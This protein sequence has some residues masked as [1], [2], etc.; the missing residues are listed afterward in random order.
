MNKKEEIFLKKLYKFAKPCIFLPLDY[1]WDCKI[2]LNEQNRNQNFILFRL[3]FGKTPYMVRVCDICAS[4]E[5]IKD[6]NLARIR[7]DCFTTKKFKFS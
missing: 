2:K 6:K 4:K 1:C 7:E 5:K 3:I